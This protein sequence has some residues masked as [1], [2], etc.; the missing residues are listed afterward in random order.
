MYKPNTTLNAAKQILEGDESLD[1]GTFHRLPSHVI[2]NE[3]YT[4]TKG[5]ESMFKTLKNGDDLNIKALDRLISILKTIKKEAKAFK[6][7]DKVPLMYEGVNMKIHPKLVKDLSDI[8]SKII[9]PTK[10]VSTSS[11]EKNGIVILKMNGRPK[12]FIR[13]FNKEAKHLLHKEGALV[14][15]GDEWDHDQE[16]IVC[17]LK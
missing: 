14:D 15:D 11:D 10:I 8:A 1:E 2:G 12:S 9:A 16:V 7:G 17:Y 13:Q 5:V 4:L 6:T 3:F